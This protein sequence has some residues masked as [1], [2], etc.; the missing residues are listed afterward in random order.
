M[1]LGKDEATW[2]LDGALTGFQG[3]DSGENLQEGRFSGAVVPDDRESFVSPD[4]DIDVSEHHMVGE[5][6]GAVPD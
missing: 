3:N 2:K 6:D 4:A 1:L 5:T